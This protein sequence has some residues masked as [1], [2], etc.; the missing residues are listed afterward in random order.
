MRAQSSI[1]T[2]FWIYHLGGS[3]SLEVWREEC[4]LLCKRLLQSVSANGNQLCVSLSKTYWRLCFGGFWAFSARV[5]LLREGCWHFGG[6]PASISPPL[7]SI[8]GQSPSVSRT[9]G[10]LSC[11]SSWK[12]PESGLQASGLSSGLVSKETPYLQRVPPFA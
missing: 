9:R 2:F 6:D 11:R 4:S 5:G 12:H 1:R 10:F 8:C 7:H 3:R